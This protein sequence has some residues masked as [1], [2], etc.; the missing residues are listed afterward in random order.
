MCLKLV[1]FALDR[2]IEFL[3]NKYNSTHI[4]RF[5]ARDRFEKYERE[6]QTDEVGFDYGTFA[7]LKGEWYSLDGACVAYSETLERLKE[8]RKAMSDDT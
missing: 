5:T 6:T 2:E 1:L 8:L 7:Y 4:E 3:Q